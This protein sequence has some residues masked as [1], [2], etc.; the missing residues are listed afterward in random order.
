MPLPPEPVLAAFNA[1]FHP[2]RTQGELVGPAWDNGIRVGDIVFAEARPWTGWSA[3]VREKLSVPG[4]RIARPVLTADG[5]YTAA[6]WKATQF[7]EGQLRGR[8]DETVQLALRLDDALDV[9]PLPTMDRLEDVFA[10]AERAAWE[11]SGEAYSDAELAHLPLVTAHMDLLGTTIFSG[12]NPPALID[13]VPSAA[14]RP[15]GWTA[16]IVM[17]DGLIAG[18]VDGDICTRFAAV[19]GMQ[20]LLLRAVAYRRYIN[21]LHPRSKATVRSNIERV[22][23]ALVSAASDRL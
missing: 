6:G 15:A 22:E 16:A 9:A 14:P 2:R 12:A 19:P 8:I 10:R 13:V 3:K 21:I 11:E 20:Q 5:R 7:V 18:A 23:E 4:A 17:V 1:E